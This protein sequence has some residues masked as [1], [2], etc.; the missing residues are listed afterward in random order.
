MSNSTPKQDTID[1][2]LVEFRT[3]GNLDNA[4]DALAARRLGVNGTDLHCLDILESR[5]GLTAG[6]LALEAGLTSGAVTGVI[7]R[8]E[9]AGY[10]R[11]AADPGDRRK[12]KV[13][14][15]PAFYQ[16]A[17]EIWAPLKQE[18]DV[19]LA[20]RFTAHELDDVIAFLRATNDLARRH[21]ERLRN[22]G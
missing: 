16:R 8:L 6:E 9:R 4:F 14:V 11:R 21:L 2:L 22:M 5:S 3:S 13:E 15:T 20:R 18:W 10:A 7:D 17:E 19:V 12:V 1:A